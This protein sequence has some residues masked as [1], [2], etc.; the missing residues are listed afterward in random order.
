VLD[1][2]Q[3]S[4]DIK[5]I[6]T[7]TIALIICGEPPTALAQM[8]PPVF[9][10]SMPTQQLITRI[11]QTLAWRCA[12]R[13]YV[14][15]N[16]LRIHGRGILIL[17]EP[18]CG[19]SSLSLQLL[20][21]GH[22]IIADDSVYFYNDGLGLRGHGTARRRIQWLHLRQQGFIDL[23]KAFS[24]AQRPVA[25]TLDAIIRIAQHKR[26][27]AP[28]G[29]MIKLGTQSFPL[30][31]LQADIPEACEL[32]EEFATKV[33]QRQVSLAENLTLHAD[34]GNAASG[35]IVRTL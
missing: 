19:K 33:N 9:R 28:P 21:R 12:P 10:A 6:P 5:P 35:E 3:Y 18:G 7:T 17:G 25:Q 11:T 29:S 15:G 27:I 24:I 2:E 8:L 32:V 4:A 14:H 22:A 16:F 31:E 26:P 23:A 13:L 1:S 20:Q 30:L 34:V